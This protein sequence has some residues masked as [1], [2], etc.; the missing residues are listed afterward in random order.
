MSILVKL[1][2]NM[3]S[4]FPKFLTDVMYNWYLGFDHRNSNNCDENFG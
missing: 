4:F 3:T 2:E 1:I